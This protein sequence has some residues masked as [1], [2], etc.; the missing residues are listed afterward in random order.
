MPTLTLG[1]TATLGPWLP[2]PCGLAPDGTLAI[3]GCT[4]LASDV[5]PI[6][7]EAG[8]YRAR[9][10]YVPASHRPGEQAFRPLLDWGEPW[11]KMVQPM[12][13]VAVQHLI[14]PGNPWGVNEYAKVDYLPEVPDETIDIPDAPP[15]SFSPMRAGLGCGRPT[16]RR[17]SADWWR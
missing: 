7:L 12:P 5:Q 1:S 4:Q 10:R 11:P 14:D 6:H 3:T 15:T 16:A 2:I 8:K 13:Y 17:S 9:I